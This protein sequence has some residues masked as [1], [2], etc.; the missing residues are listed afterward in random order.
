MYA[1]KGIYRHGAIECIEKP[2]FPEP[3]E[4][5]IVFPEHEKVVKKIRGR[6][7]G[8]LINYDDMEAELQSL[9]RQEADHL[10]H[11]VN[12]SQ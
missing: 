2:A 7:Q 8:Y 5:L 6:F 4:V 9:S 12:E 10:L 3:V 11:E 1:I